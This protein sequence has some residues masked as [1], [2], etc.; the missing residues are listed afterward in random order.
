MGGNCCE[1]YGT[2]ARITVII[3]TAAGLAFS[4]LAAYSCEFIEFSGVLGLNSGKAGLFQ[5]TEPTSGECIKYPDQV[6]VGGTDNTARV[7]SALAALFGLIALVLILFEFCICKLCCARLIESCVYAVAYICQGLTFLIYNNGTLC[8][9]VDC[10]W[11]QGSTWS[12]LALC[13]Y[14][15]SSCIM[16][17]T[18][19][20]TPLFCKHRE[21]KKV[22]KEAKKMAEEQEAKDKAAEEAEQGQ[23]AAASSGS[24]DEEAAAH[25][26]AY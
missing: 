4:I 7:C 10:S 13:F 22:E 8:V 5:Y 17:C 23:P 18:P 16:C 3:F 12:V 26:S 14:F 11:S 1:A 25:A 20:S 2:C 15:I 9:E 19:R 6:D 24:D 21:H